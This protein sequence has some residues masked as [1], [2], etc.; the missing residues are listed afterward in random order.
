MAMMQRQTTPL[1]RNRLVDTTSVDEA[2]DA[3][4]RIFCP[5]F[6]GP[7]GRNSDTFH[8]RHNAVALPGFSVN[9]VS[10][11]ARVDIDPGE[12]ARFFLLQIPVNGAAHIRCGTSSCD[13]AP[14]SRASLLSPTLA[15][16]MTW[17]EDCEKIIV[18]IDREIMQRQF[19][20]L[21]G[22]S[23]HCVEFAAGVDLTSS[24]GQGLARHVE[25]MVSSAE[26]CEAM[27][28]AYQVMLRDGLTTLLLTGFSH[29]RSVDFDQPARAAAPVAVSRAEAFMREH[30]GRPISSADIAAHAGVSLR[31]LQD[32]FKRSRNMTI[33]DVLLEIRLDQ[34][35]AALT[36]RAAPTTS[37]ADAAFAAGF[38][39]LGR[40]AQAY[41]Q[42][43]GESPSQTLN[44]RR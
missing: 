30:A 44:R 40:A 4:G 6:L 28:E 25:M 17:S 26:H 12:L 13:S 9:Y 20:A 34:F 27:P 14:G 42:R 10:Y 1:G 31:S 19:L 23:E 39:H 11:G 16:R 43:F 2:R 7:T 24:A 32:A 3:I 41:R 33:G 36:D 22:R 37:V 35:R 8:A 15:T 18:L 21:G 29:S 5:H 38:G